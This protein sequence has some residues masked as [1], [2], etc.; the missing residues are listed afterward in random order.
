MQAFITGGSQG[1]PGFAYVNLTSISN[2]G[3]TGYIVLSA[4]QI[5]ELSGDLT[6]GSGNPGKIEE[7]P[8]I[9]S[10]IGGGAASEPLPLYLESADRQPAFEAPLSR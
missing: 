4:E 8:V 3:A 7:A 6:P 10:L 1:K 5:A 2:D 9:L